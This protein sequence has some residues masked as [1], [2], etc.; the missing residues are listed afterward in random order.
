MKISGYKTEEVL[1]RYNIKSEGGLK[2][3][4]EQLVN[5]SRRNPLK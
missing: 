1:E 2:D 3:A 5:I 4:A